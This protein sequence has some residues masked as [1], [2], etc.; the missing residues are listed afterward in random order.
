MVSAARTLGCTPWQAFLQV[1]L[2]LSVPGLAAGTLLC[3]VLAAGSYVTPALLG[4][5]DDFLIGNL[6]Y[7]AMMD[8]VNW[9]LGATL[10]FV[11]LVL[12]GAVVVIYNRFMGL[13]QIYK[14]LS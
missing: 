1:T 8:E 7:D 5:P 12:L 13:S 9:P 10:S 14:G 4:G 6:I 2:P 11:L 3:F